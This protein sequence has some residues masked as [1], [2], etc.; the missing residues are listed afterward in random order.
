MK[1]S[2]CLILITLIGMLYSCGNTSRTGQAVSPDEAPLV[3]PEIN[4]K[5]SGEATTSEIT[6]PKCGHQKKEQMP[7]NA[8]QYFHL[9]YML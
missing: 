6:C 2:F 8:C 3:A 5:K 9:L 1:K 7:T 4:G